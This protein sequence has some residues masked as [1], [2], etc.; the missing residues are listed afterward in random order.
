MH[1]VRFYV[2]V[3]YRQGLLG[4][5]ETG[6]AMCSIA[7]TD[8]HLNEVGVDGIYP[9]C[10]ELDTPDPLQRHPGHVGCHPA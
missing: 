5:L 4:H 6:I 10:N 9:H 1:C 2:F 3:T 8:T 7:D